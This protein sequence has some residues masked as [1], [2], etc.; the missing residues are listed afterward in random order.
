MQIRPRIV[1]STSSKS[2]APGTFGFGNHG[3]DAPWPGTR[4][5]AAASRKHVNT[6]FVEPKPRGMRMTYLGLTEL[7]G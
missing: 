2:I 4:A 7:A 5:G 3:S 1:G 6:N